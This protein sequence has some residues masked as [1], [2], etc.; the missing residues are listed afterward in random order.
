MC[1]GEAMKEL[2]TFSYLM[3]PPIL[4]SQGL[5]LSIQHYIDGLADR[6]GLVIKF[7]T[8][9]KGDKF[10]LRLQRPVFRIIQEALANTYRH[11]RPCGCPS[12]LGA[13]AS[14]CMS[15]SPIMGGALKVAASENNTPLGRMS[16]SEAS[17][18]DC[19]GMAANCRITP[20]A[21]RGNAGTRRPPG[22]RHPSERSKRSARPVISRLTGA[23]SGGDAE[24]RRSGYVPWQ[25]R[26]DLGKRRRLG[27]VGE[28]RADTHT[29]RSRSPSPSR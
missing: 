9:C 13:L 23:G 27:Q 17:R 12:R 24:R 14:D 6:S 22:R 25:Q 3:N 1:L 5:Y 20:A 21:R 29:A 19:N 11:A 10:P 28:H 4:H 26:L 18:C 16:V 2:R 8:N 7:N 15:S